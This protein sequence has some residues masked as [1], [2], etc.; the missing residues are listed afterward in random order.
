MSQRRQL[1]RSCAEAQQAA[2]DLQEPDAVISGCVTRLH[3]IRRHEGDTI[4]A[5]SEIITRGY[6]EIERRFEQRGTIPGIPTGFR[7]LDRKLHGLGPQFYVLAGSSGMGKSALAAQIAR[8]AAAA[9]R[10]VGIISL[11][12][13]PLQIALRDISS[14]SDVPLSR[15]LS[16]NVHDADWE[17]MAR[18][19]GDLHALPIWGAFSAFDVRQIERV[20][21]DM[22][23]R[24]GIEL[25]ICDYLQL[26]RVDNHDG[27]REQEVSAVSKMHKHKAQQHGVPNLVISSLNRALAN[28]QDKRPTTADL[29]E[30]GS[31]E[32]DADVI[33]FVYRDEVY[34]CK[35]PP[36]RDCLCER[37]GKA[38]IIVA[39]GRMEGTGAVPLLWNG[40]TTSFK[41]QE[42]AA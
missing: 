25:V 35:C 12:M 41:D 20:I 15:L 27:T 23:Q 24:L 36:D 30:S 1:I 28:R 29:R 3:D 8:N 31:I 9:G 37:R 11:E 5:Y 18:S 21:D 17:R 33:L 38:E 10:K 6:N 34:N 32:Y 26:E 40:A 42:G 39:K 4:I 22:V 16:G 14:A 19:C 2:Y 13:G 7:E